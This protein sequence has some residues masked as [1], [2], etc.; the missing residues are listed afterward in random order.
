MAS[1]WS[2]SVAVH[3]RAEE[4]VQTHWHCWELAFQVTYALPEEDAADMSEDSSIDRLIESLDLDEDDGDGEATTAAPAWMPEPT[5]PASTVSAVGASAVNPSLQA[6]LTPKSKKRAVKKASFKRKVRKGHPSTASASSA[7]MASGPAGST[8]RASAGS[9]GMAAKVH[10][11][12]V[13][14]AEE[15]EEADAT[16]MEAFIKYLEDLGVPEGAFPATPPTGRTSYTVSSKDGNGTK[17]EVQHTNK[18][19]Y[20][21]KAMDPDSLTTKSFSWRRWGG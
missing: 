11:D 18:L 3:K 12:K 7:G 14:K 13:E 19:Y 10:F 17:I 15:A 4:L 9:A 2:T 8:S 5:A 1:G 6:K 20:V 16:F 21:K